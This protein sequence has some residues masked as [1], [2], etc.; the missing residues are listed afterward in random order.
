MQGARGHE[1]ASRRATGV[2]ANERMA[3]GDG[4][5]EESLILQNESLTGDVRL[6][7]VRGCDERAFGA[8]FTSK[9]AWCMIKR[10]ILW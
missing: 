1:A 8:C 5:E 9:Q 6:L 2:V 4:S 10:M 3:S 7:L